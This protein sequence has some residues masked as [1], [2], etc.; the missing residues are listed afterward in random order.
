MG[1]PK[2]LKTK[3]ALYVCNFMDTAAFLGFAKFHM[4][5]QLKWTYLPTADDR[6]GRN[7]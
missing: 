2:E 4:A 5:M 1:C 3:A 7:R 6:R